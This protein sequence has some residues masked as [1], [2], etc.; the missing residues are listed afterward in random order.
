MWAASCFLRSKQNIKYK[1]D[2]KTYFSLKDIIAIFQN[3]VEANVLAQSNGHDNLGHNMTSV[4]NADD[5]WVSPQFR[6][7]KAAFPGSP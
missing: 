3:H 4:G 5:L 6:I 1:Y 2:Y 7:P